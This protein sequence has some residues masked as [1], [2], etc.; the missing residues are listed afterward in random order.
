V[1]LSAQTCSERYWLGVFTFAR[2]CTEPLLYH[3]LQMMSITILGAQVHEHCSCDWLLTCLK[4]LAINLLYLVCT[5][6]FLYFDHDP[7]CSPG[8]K[9][10]SVQVSGGTCMENTVKSIIEASN[11]PL[12]I[13]MVGVGDGPFD[14]YVLFVSALLCFLLLCLRIPYIWP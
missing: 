13:L 1:W 4:K 2:V 5:M 7:H 9:C 12:S 11:Y 10:F 6:K 8:K 3:L 14:E